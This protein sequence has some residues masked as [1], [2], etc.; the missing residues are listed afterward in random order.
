MPSLRLI[1]ADQL[2]HSLPSLE[3]IDSKKDAVLMCEVMEETTYAPHHQKKIAFLF[4]AMRHFAKELGERGIYVRY[5]TLDDSEN[6][7]SFTGEI[8]R[9]VGDFKPDKI[10]VTEP[11]EYRVL[12]A[13]KSWEKAFGIAVDPTHA[14]W[15][16]IMS[17]PHGQKTKSNCA[18]SFST[19]RCGKNIIFC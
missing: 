6:T 18:W 9:A 3:G 16:T 4:S 12:E 17:L 5:I 2:S 15:R 1:L 19:A 11:G 14:F 13:M 10:I 8:K 7:G